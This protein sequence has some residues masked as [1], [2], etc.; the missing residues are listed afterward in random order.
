MVYF[1]SFIFLIKI[2]KKYFL[3]CYFY[4]IIHF[5]NN[6]K[7][8]DDFPYYHFA[9]SYYLTQDPLMIG[10]GLFYLCFRTPSS[11]FY[12]NSIFYLPFVE[13][14]FFHYSYFRFCKSY[15]Y[16]RFIYKLKTNNY[17]FIF[18]FFF[19]YFIYKYFFL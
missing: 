5:F 1:Y 16:K 4:N 12:L 17:D 2:K 8:H 14:F 3:F 18:Y 6:F 19:K 13:F 15:F 9:Y 11:I 10:T 7:T